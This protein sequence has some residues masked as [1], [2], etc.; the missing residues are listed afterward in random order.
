MYINHTI[1][2]KI[3]LN[4]TNKRYLFVEI[5]KNWLTRI[6]VNDQYSRFVWQKKKKNSLKK[7]INNLL[8]RVF[9]I[10][11]KNKKNTV[12]FYR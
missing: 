10:Y 7:I 9:Q 11:S 1:Y 3:N 2:R 12:F 8:G 5:F 4:K 6:V